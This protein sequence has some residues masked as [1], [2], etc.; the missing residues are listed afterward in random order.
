MTRLGK[1]IQK[2][3]SNGIRI[4]LYDILNIIEELDSNGNQIALYAQSLEVDRP[5]AMNRSGE[6]SFYQQDAQG[7]V[8]SLTNAAGVI[9]DT[10]A[11]D[12]FGNAAS[13]RKL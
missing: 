4:Y 9:T 2:S 6:T 8:K 12:S 13:K 7:S 3:S 5:L 10:Y 11:Y 1:R